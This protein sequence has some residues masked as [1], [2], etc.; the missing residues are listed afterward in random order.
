MRLVIDSNQMQSEQLRKFLS[1][2]T[3]NQAVLTDFAAMEAYKGDTLNS[4]FKSMAI[5][6]EYPGQ[7]LVLKGSR[8]LFGA[9]GRKKGLQRRLIDEQQTKEFPLFIKALRIAQTAD[10]R[11]QQQVLAHGRASD[12]HFTKMLAEA[13]EM[14]PVFDSLGKEYSKDERAI[15]RNRGSY[16]PE[17]ADKLVKT[18]LDLA[19]RIALSSRLVQRWPTYAELP[20]TYFFRVTL[21]CYLMAITKAAHGGMDRTRPDKLR[22][23]LVDMTFVAYGT[24]FDGILS[25]DDGVNSMFSEVCL[26]LSALLNAEVPAMARL[27]KK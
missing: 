10:P 8:K 19:A 4:I 7:V 26:I 17:L 6:S 5:V 2:S 14:R 11:T 24:Y 20:N 18:V 25:E 16:T 3:N 9:P 12:E 13:E 21:A 23:D 27:L 1:A 15:L 22:N